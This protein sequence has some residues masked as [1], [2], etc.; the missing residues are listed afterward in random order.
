MNVTAFSPAF[1]LLYVFALLWILM[2][3]DLNA[4]SR[5]QRRLILSALLLLCAVNHLLI[6]LVGPAM[7]N[8]KLL[9]PFLHLPTFLLFLYIARRGVVKTAFMIL[10]AL[11][12]TAPTVLISNQVNR[13]LDV[14]SFQFMID[15]FSY[16]LML[17]LAQIVFRKSFNYLIV[18]GDDRFF[19]LFSLV[20]IAYYIYIFAVINL[21]MSS[22]S[23]VA[24][25][26]VRL[27]PSAMVFLF[28]FLLPY[29]YKTLSERMLLQSAQ[30]A[31]QQK[32]ASTEDQLALLNETNT[33]MATYR[34]DM[35]HQLIL[36]DGLLVDG[37]TEQAQEFVKTVMADL[38]TLTPKPFCGNETVNLLC[39]SYDSKARHLGVQLK[40][41]AM[42]PKSLPL[43]DTE[44]CSV[45]S[46]GLENALRA[47]SQPELS[48][49]WIEFYCE[50]KQNKLFMQIQNTYTGQVVMQNGLPVSTRD[51]HGYGCHSIQ[52]IAQRNG[53]LCSFKAENG[54]FTLRLAFPLS[55]DFG[56]QNTNNA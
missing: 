20:P 31:L 48:D 8:G 34:H 10:T 44:L 37:K 13:F 26:A 39:S 17:L 56:N 3:V 32:L 41:N 18:Y 23:S 53:G 19:L 49:K 22:V 6:G 51:G 7:Y 27:L 25:Y 16:A 55:A 36:L 38:D 1:V 29:M 28:Y 35:R 33:Q 9:F 40:V 42:L 52:S 54:L 21:D 12:F 11:V 24:G 43:S 15:L 14:G 47:A 4:F 50:V 5:K 30:N 46:N 2:G 45:I